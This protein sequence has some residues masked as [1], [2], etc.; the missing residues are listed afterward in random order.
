[1]GRLA[2]A[3]NWLAFCFPT[4]QPYLSLLTTATAGICWSV[5]LLP[6]RVLLAA[7][8]GHWSTQQKQRRRQREQLWLHCAGADCGPDSLPGGPLHAVGL[9]SAQA[10]YVC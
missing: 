9:A 2:A 1:M 5:V 7:G 10:G 8:Q 6:L 4:W 3:A